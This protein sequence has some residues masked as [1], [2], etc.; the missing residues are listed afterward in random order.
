MIVVENNL[1]K[2][3]LRIAPIKSLDRRLLGLCH[4]LPGRAK[5]EPV[6]ASR[7]HGVTE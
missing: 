5:K 2:I 4:C 3:Y 1:L 6:S 7:S